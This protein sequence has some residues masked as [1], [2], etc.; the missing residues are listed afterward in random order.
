MQI[1]A[2]LFDKLKVISLF[3]GEG[4][5]SVKL[6]VM[7]VIT[8]DYHMRIIIKKKPSESLIFGDIHSKH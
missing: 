1:R 2:Q 8:C 4:K 6:E 7:S 5:L 3:N